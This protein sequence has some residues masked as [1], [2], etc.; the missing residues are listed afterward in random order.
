MRG[1]RSRAYATALATAALA[2]PSAPGPKH[3]PNRARRHRLNPGRRSV[4]DNRKARGIRAAAQVYTDPKWRA[5]MI[6]DAAR[7]C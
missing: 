1:R 4:A 3:K 5:Q 6:A 2:L 7:T